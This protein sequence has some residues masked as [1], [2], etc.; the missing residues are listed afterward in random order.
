[1]F[2]DY[3]SPYSSAK[4]G[5]SVLLFAIFSLLFIQ[6]LYKII[7]ICITFLFDWLS[8]DWLRFC[9]MQYA[10]YAS[11][12]LRITNKQ[13]IGIS[14]RKATMWRKEKKGFKNESVWLSAH[15]SL[16]ILNMCLCVRRSGK[17]MM[18]NER[19]KGLLFGKWTQDRWMD[20]WMVE[21]N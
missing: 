6:R 16:E 11:Y 15:F 8:A 20:A 18:M 5:I 17:N 13:F 12:I 2:I 3:F 19:R 9:I 1:M 14:E 21:W 4:N 10:A 7:T